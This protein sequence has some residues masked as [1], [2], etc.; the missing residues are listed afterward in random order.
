L[1]QNR[2]REKTKEFK[3]EYSK[4]ASVEG[5]ISQGGASVWLEK[6]ALYWNS[7]DMSSAVSLID[8]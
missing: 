1:Q 8:T 2:Q 7:E 4:R 6:V 3:E 5:T